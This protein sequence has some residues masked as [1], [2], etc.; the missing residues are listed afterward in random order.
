[1]TYLVVKWHY[2]GAK[3]VGK[4]TQSSGTQVIEALQKQK[5]VEG[6]PTGVTWSLVEGGIVEALIASSRL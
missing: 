2:N 3:E 6:K 1:M 5:A 4:L